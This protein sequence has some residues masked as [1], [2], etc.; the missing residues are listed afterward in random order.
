MMCRQDKT[1]RLL[2]WPH[3]SGRAGSSG[4]WAGLEF[5]IKQLYNLSPCPLRHTQG[6]GVWASGAGGPSSVQSPL[7]F[8]EQEKQLIIA[9][10][11]S[12]LHQGPEPCVL[13]VFSFF[14]PFV[15]P[16]V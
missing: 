4:S 10:V 14:G 2:H 9:Q 6:W 13:E 8:P 16:V 12:P 3:C 7:G 11:A 15:P 5:G 1:K